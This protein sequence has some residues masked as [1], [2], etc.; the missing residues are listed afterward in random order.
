MG[1]GGICVQ[2]HCFFISSKTSFRV[3]RKSLLKEAELWRWHMEHEHTHSVFDVLNVSGF[4]VYS[5]KAQ[6]E[7]K[8]FYMILK[9][10]E[11]S[12]SNSQG[13]GLLLKW[14]CAMPFFLS[15]STEIDKDPVN[16]RCER[17]LSAKNKMW[18][19]QKP[20]LN[21]LGN[22]NLSWTFLG[23]RVAQGHFSCWFYFK[24]ISM[25]G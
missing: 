25:S 20:W 17:T 23:R 16:I 9:R 24:N 1:L 19:K 11:L 14:P 2:T 10:S 15:A 22:E 3:E 13:H 18:R 6:K 12:F 21:T 8:Q 7:K 5:K 4:G